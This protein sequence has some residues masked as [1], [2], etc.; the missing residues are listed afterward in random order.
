MILT[1]LIRIDCFYLEARRGGAPPRGWS[2]RSARRLVH[3]VVEHLEAAVGHEDLRHA[4]ALR[5]LVVLDDG[6]HDA[7]Q[8]EGRAVERVA[9]LDL[10]GVGMAEA[11]VEAVGLVAAEVGHRTDFQ[12]AL[13]G[14]APGLEVVA[15]GG[16]EAHVAA[17]E[18]EDVVGKLQLGE[19]ALHVVEH[20]LVGDLCVL[21]RVD[22]DD[23]DLVKLMETVETAHVLAI[24]AGLAT[25]AGG[26]GAALDGEFVLLDDL[27][28][29]EVGHRHLGGG[30]QVEVVEVGMVHLA[31]LVGELARAQ[32]AG[33]IDHEGRL[34]LGIARLAGLVEEEG[35]QRAL[36]AG[37][38]ADI[39]GEART[40]D[41]DAEVEIDEV[42]LLQQIPV[43]KGAFGKIGL[44]AAFLHHHVAT[45]IAALG[46]LVGGYVGDGEQHLV[47]VG[48]G[49]LHDFLQGLVGSL[50]LGH[51]LLHLVGLVT[52]ARLHQPAN[53][54]R[55]LILTLLVGVELLLGLTT[56]AVVFQHLLHGLACVG[57]AFLL[58]AFHHTFSFLTDEL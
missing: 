14:G 52:L 30:D 6:G 42:E 21:R 38:L 39:D 46:H 22:T 4:D 41:L 12:P 37:H 26:V 35:F 5:G 45:G 1:L 7:R 34:H 24:A 13:L 40:G 57:E 18:T 53:L 9:E 56:Q 17:T 44:H 15:D 58:Q 3:L 47:H 50:E 33:L 51:L 55:E 20:L 36:E 32:S 43:T 25:E 2:P 23:L 49:L 16:G 19:Q 31:L 28:A 11:A 27:V 54:A 48:L 29:E 10:L 8:G